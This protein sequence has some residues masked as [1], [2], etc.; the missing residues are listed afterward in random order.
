MDSSRFWNT[1]RGPE[2]FLHTRDLWNLGS[3]RIVDHAPGLYDYALGDASNA[4]SRDKVKKF[5]REVLYL[6]ATD[7]LF[8]FDHVVS[9]DPSFRKT[10][11]LHGVNQPSVDTDDG[12][13]TASTKEFKNASTFRFREGS[14]E[15]LVHSL[16]PRERLITRRGG[17]GADFFCPGD[18][19]GGAW[20]SGE[21]WRLEPQEGS[22]LPEDPK[23]RRMWKTFWGADFARIQPSNRKNV[24]SGAW[25]IEVSPVA[26]AEEDFFLHV[27]EIGTLGITGRRTELIDGVTFIGA[28][29]ESGPFVLFAA[30]GSAAAGGEVSL[31]NLACD[32]LIASGLQPDTVYELSFT[33]PNVS[34]SS[35]SALPGVLTDLLRLRSNSKG[36]LRLEKPH[37]GDLRLRIAQV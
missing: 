8:V 11:L 3:M 13:G 31:P 19:L 30:S 9:V 35:A 37:C 22:A 2:D 28:A 25:R 16:L 1:V 4:Y 32:S 15:L 17:P 18:E 7:L 10:W 26:P 20:G 24:V 6:P 14:G 36:I 12:K 23:L 21:N 29:S 5:T 34:A 27:F 33:G